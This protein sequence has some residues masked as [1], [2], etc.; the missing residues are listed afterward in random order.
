M[1]MA[2]RMLKPYSIL[3][4]FLALVAFF[5][6]GLSHAGIVEAVKN[7]GLAGGAIVLG[8]GVFWAVIGLIIALVV[9][10]KI[11]GKAIFRLNIILAIISIGFYAF[12]HIKYVE[13]QK[14]KAKENREIQYPKQQTKPAEEPMAN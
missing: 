13:R 11:N 2:H 8:Y 3:L 14:T 7:Q 6:V 10:Y 9:S 12:F 4:Y 5:F 1:I